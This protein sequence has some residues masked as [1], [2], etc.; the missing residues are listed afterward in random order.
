MRDIIKDFFTRLVNLIT[1]VSVLWIGLLVISFAIGEPV[2]SL[3]PEPSL[4]G[5]RLISGSDAL[6]VVAAVIMIGS[7][8]VSVHYLKLALQLK[9]GVLSSRR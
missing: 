5:W 4:V 8:R 3:A 2:P 9:R 6:Y 7:M 1:G